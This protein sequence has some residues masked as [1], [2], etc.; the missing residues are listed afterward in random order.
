MLPA[1]QIR[2]VNLMLQTKRLNLLKKV[3]PTIFS[4]LTK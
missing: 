4:Q 2:D 3:I 1:I